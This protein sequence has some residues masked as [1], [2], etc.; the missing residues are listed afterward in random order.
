MN[1][2]KEQKN[3]TFSFYQ[4]RKKIA[5]IDP[6][7]WLK[8][9]PIF[10]KF[11]WEDKE[12]N[13]FFAAVGT[14]KKFA[15]PQYFSEE[16]TLFSL[17]PFDTQK[18]GFPWEGFPTT[19]PSLERFFA[20]PR[21]EL[22]TQDDFSV[23]VENALST[24]EVA[25]PSGEN[26]PSLSPVT[27][28]S[29]L[30][31]IYP[32]SEVWES[33][34]YKALEKIKKRCFQ[35]VVLA[36]VKEYLLDASFSLYEYL[37][38][39]RQKRKNTFVFLYIPNE[40]EAFFSFSPERLYQRKACTVL[41]E[42]IAGTCLK[43]GLFSLPQFLKDPKEQREFQIVQDVLSKNLSEMGSQVKI[44]PRKILSTQNLHHFYA[45]IQAELSSPH[46]DEKLLAKIHPTPATLGYP[47]EEALSF[48][49]ESEPFTRG[50]YAAPVGWIRSDRAEFIVGIRSGLIRRKSCYLFSGT[51]LVEGSSPQKEW[52]ELNHKLAFYETNFQSV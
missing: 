22:H 18:K 42:A 33:L 39:L 1:F 35:K 6:L 40:E 46:E 43:K 23:Q 9:T 36:R 44:S 52:N 19:A 25:F 29:E 34:V 10:P 51:G 16:V 20:L 14:I 26:T 38:F 7:T 4:A 5:P 47:K 32:N 11:Y 21:F 49:L 3:A 24:D 12:K 27:F 37:S 17:S 2:W 41:T 50:Y 31:K 13:L 45:S 30:Q 48:L 8:S 28:H 15:R